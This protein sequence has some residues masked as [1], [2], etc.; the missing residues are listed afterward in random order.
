MFYIF[1][2]HFLYDNIMIKFILTVASI[3]V[4][5][6]IDLLL[7]YLYIPDLST[8]YNPV[9]SIFG[10]SWLPLIGFQILLLTLISAFGAFYFFK[11]PIKVEDRGLNFSD[12]IYCYFF[13][14]LKPW[15]QRMFSLP[16]NLNQH[17]IF[18]GFIFISSAILVS[19]FA[20]FN[21]LMLIFR[22]TWYNQ[23]LIEY[24]RFF[25]PGTFVIIALVSFFLFFGKQY[26]RYLQQQSSPKPDNAT[27]L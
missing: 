19:L 18:N 12:F 5:R 15:P 27:I 24:Y 7:T 4:L 14:E 13:G 23:F 16:K 26:S 20:I 6:V 8:E 21:N 9:V 2:H 11:P 22:V 17:L 3:S 1:I 25:F 10:A